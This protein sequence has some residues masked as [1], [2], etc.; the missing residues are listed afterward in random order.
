VCVT[1][2]HK[3]IR[4]SN[5]KQENQKAKEKDKDL[6]AIKERRRN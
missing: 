6:D 2:R 1:K 5:N 4:Q 3:L